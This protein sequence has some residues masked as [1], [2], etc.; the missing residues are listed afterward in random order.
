MIIGLVYL[1]YFSFFAGNF[2]F[3]RFEFYSKLIFGFLMFLSCFSILGSISYYLYKLSNPIIVF[4]IIIL[5]I[6]YGIKLLKYPL[7]IVIDKFRIDKNFII[8]F[9]LV[10]VYSA[11]LVFSLKY[12]NSKATTDSINTPWKLISANFFILYFVMSILILLISYISKSKYILVLLSIHFAFSFSIILIIY[13]LGFGYD[14]HLHLASEK[15][16]F[17]NGTF[18]PKPPY[19][20]GQYSIVVVL[21]KLFNI[22]VV[23]IDRALLIFSASLLLPV[24]IFMFLRDKLLYKKFVVF[25]ST[26]LFL[27]FNYSTLTYTTPQGL[28]NLFLII[29]IFL[30]TLFVNYKNVYIAMIVLAL[31]IFVIHPISGIPAFLFLTLFFLWNSKIKNKKTAFYSLSAISCFVLPIA[32]LIFNYLKKFSLEKLGQETGINLLSTINP[33][34]IFY[35]RF[36]NIYDFVYL[37]AK[38]INLLILLIAIFGIMILIKSKEL[39]EYFVYIAMFIVLL[40]NYAIM[41]N[42]LKFPFL[43]EFSLRIF[44]MAFYFI[45]PVVFVALSAL[46][47]RI[48]YYKNNFKIFVLVLFAILLSVG[49]YISYPRSDK[50]ENFKGYSV[51]QSSIKAV[52]YIEN[53]FSKLDY[54]VL[55]DQIVGASLIGKYGFRKYYRDEFYYSLPT[56]IKDN[57]YSDFLNILEPDSN[58]QEV[59]NNAKHKAGVENIFVVISSYWNPGTGVLIDLKKTAKKWTDIDNGKIFIFEY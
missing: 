31:S 8:R 56:N 23:F 5:P 19:Y 21:A 50:Y 40:F 6:I 42:F 35:V 46:V 55:S 37:Y 1:L 59:I 45:L 58:K 22:S 15:L 38:N 14:P 26:L 32:F 49:F 39:K 3:M 52:E 11:I 47:N 57:T 20:I 17:L 24:S 48:F 13:K 4:I 41:I 18:L 54:V 44:N 10:I 53:N 28:A 27:L 51:S 2:F 7:G 29:L 36:I 43:Y 34:N 16:M 30:S 9:F 12:L 33:L 25:I